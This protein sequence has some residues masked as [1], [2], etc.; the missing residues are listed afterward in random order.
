MSKQKLDKEE[1]QK[2]VLGGLMFLFVVYSYFNLLLFPMKKRTF[3]AKVGITALEPKM[4]D[5]K[6]EWERLEAVKAQVP[7]A[8]ATMAQVNMLIPEGAPIAWFP[9][10]VNDFFK[11]VG[12]E[13][14]QIRPASQNNEVSE[15]ELP[16]YRRASW[17]V[18]IP[19]VDCIPF[20]SAVAP[21]RKS[22]IVG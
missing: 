13:K 9:T 19:R 3:T 6:A 5:L 8:E 17:T 16:G 15:K 18:E 10:R 2:I 14:A 12:L 21:V 11:N 4:N 7:K 20:F 22:G 1:V